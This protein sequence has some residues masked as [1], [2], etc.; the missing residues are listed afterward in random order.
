MLPPRV[1]GFLSSNFLDM[2]RLRASGQWLQEDGGFTIAIPG[3]YVIVSEHG[4]AGAA[5]AYAAGAYRFIGGKGEKLAVVWAPAVRRGHSPFH[6][7]D[8]EF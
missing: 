2:G 4:V 1:R 6:L 8:R 3:E 7:R 5:R